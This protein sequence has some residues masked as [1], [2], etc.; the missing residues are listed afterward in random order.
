MTYTVTQLRRYKSIRKAPG[1]HWLVISTQRLRLGLTLGIMAAN[2]AKRALHYLVFKGT[3]R[4][5]NYGTRVVTFLK[6]A[7][8]DRGNKATVI[9]RV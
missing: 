3:V 4:E 2:T 6:K 7:I 8:E 9:G 5:G 1:N